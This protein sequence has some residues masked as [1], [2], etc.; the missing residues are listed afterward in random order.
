[1]VI[2]PFSK[3]IAIVPSAKLWLLDHSAKLASR[4]HSV[5]LWSLTDGSDA[6]LFIAS[7]NRPTLFKQQTF[8]KNKFH[9]LHKNH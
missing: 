1:M 3:I 8:Q 6:S 4:V 5:K 7:L 9:A 2:L